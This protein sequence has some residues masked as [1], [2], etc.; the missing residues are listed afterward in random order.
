MQ[1]VRNCMDHGI[2]ENV[3]DR[4]NAGKPEKGTLKLIAQNSSGEVIITVSDDG[5]GIDPEKVLNKA[6]KQGVLTKP[7]SEYTEKEIQNLILLPGFSTDRKS[8]V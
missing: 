3:Q 2:E 1:L 4:I 6:R 5:Q 8:V 7:E